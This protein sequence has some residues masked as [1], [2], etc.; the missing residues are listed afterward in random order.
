MNGLMDEWT[1]IT[2][3]E[4]M[5]DLYHRRRHIL[6]KVTEWNVLIALREMKYDKRSITTSYLLIYTELYCN[7][8]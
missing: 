2:I 6:S 4:E 7:M 5:N 8:L 1:M 3:V